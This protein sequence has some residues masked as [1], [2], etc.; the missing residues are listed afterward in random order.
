MDLDQLEHDLP[1]IAEP[2]NFTERYTD[3]LVLPPNRD[4]LTDRH[5]C[6]PPDGDPSERW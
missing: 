4:D 3:G 2:V 5:L 6:G 1:Q